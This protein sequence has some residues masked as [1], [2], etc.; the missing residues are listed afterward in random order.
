[1]GGG[2]PRGPT[3][4]EKSKG[5]GVATVGWHK[6]GNQHESPG[7]A[8]FKRSLENFMSANE[9]WVGGEGDI[10]QVCYRAPK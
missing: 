4:G 1:M 10:F 7:G 2:H 3:R 6:N 8:R 9:G 5:K